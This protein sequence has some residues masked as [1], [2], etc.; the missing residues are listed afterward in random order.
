MN[1]IRIKESPSADTR[2]AEKLITKEE[3]TKSSEMH[4]DDV[5]KVFE[6][7][8][9]QLQ[10]IASKHDWTKLE[11]IDEFHKDFEETQKSG[12]NFTELA[13]YKRHITEERHHI[14][15]RCP[16][17]VTIFDLLERIAD[18]TSAGMARSGNVFP[19]NIDPET[20]KR[21]YQN[22]IELIKSHIEV[23]KDGVIYDH[24]HLWD[25]FGLSRASFLAIPRVMLHEMPLDWQNKMAKLLWEYDQ[26][27]SNPPNLGTRVIVTDE[28]GKAVKTPEW[29]I[30]YRHPDKAELEKS[31]GGVEK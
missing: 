1:K 28:R 10:K 25:W 24:N 29:L 16:E 17:D 15:R 23:E 5:R 6:W 4:I 21:A 18:I 9:E 19:D 31:K 14:D 3:L 30:N 20:L 26:T 7:M 8:I 22:T 11:F 12:A 2:S 13:W 27:F